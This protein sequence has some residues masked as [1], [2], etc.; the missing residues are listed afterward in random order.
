M[1]PPPSR[2]WLI[3]DVAPD[4]RLLDVWP[5]PVEG[6]REEFGSFLEMVASFDPAA[7]ESAATRAL[8][9]LRLRV[10]GWLGWDDARPRPIPGR[11]ETTL[12]VRLPEELRGSARSP[13]IGGALHRTA[14]GF[15]PLYRTDDEWAAE[16][17]NATVHGVLHLGWVDQGGGRYRAELGVYVKPRGRLGDAYLALIAPFR[18]LVVYPALMR[19]MGRAWEARTPV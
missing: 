13:S 19:Q 1:T 9:A 18:H 8:F 15:V 11:T 10:G 5:L 12:R 6:G 2:H 17:S 3:A 14:A 7:A 4:F 16:I